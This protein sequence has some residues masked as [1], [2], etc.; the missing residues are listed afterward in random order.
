M[1]DDELSGFISRSIRSVWALELL[2][3]LKKDPTRSWTP[4]DLVRELRA[5]TMVVGESLDTFLAA[6]LVR[7]EAGACSY[8]PASP[9]VAELCDALEQAYRKRPVA[10][11]NAIVSRTDKIQS[12][13]NAFRLRDEPK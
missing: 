5:S 4:D 1:T 9:V 2:L 3:L 6:G 8:A 10:V 13:A 12:F 7:C 11:V